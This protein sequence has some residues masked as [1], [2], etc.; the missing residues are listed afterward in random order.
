MG[1][2]SDA[3]VDRRAQRERAGAA[4]PKALAAPAREENPTLFSP[5]VQLSFAAPPI[6]VFGTEASTWA[7][8]EPSS[9]GDALQRAFLTA[10]TSATSAFA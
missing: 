7:Q 5:K 8:P 3:L 4:T 6:R 1:W 9:L 10:H 2:A